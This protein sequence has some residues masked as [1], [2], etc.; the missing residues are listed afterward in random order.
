[1]EYNINVEICKTID[2]EFMA[3]YNTSS[4]KKKETK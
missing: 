1:M 2:R 4:K 3:K